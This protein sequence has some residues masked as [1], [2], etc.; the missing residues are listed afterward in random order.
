[1]FLFLWGFLNF[2]LNIQNVTH[3]KINW[4]SEAFAQLIYFFGF[5]WMSR[6]CSLLNDDVT[7]VT[8]EGI[9]LGPFLLDIGWFFIC[10]VE[11]LR[12]KEE[13][14]QPKPPTK[15]MGEQKQYCLGR[16]EFFFWLGCEELLFHKIYQLVGVSFVFRSVSFCRGV[17]ETPLRKKKEDPTKSFLVSIR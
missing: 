2:I 11:L 9:F 12:W 16:R 1:M 14:C 17:E 8:C 5:F 6:A 4:I 13:D 7:I 15:I 3:R 10:R